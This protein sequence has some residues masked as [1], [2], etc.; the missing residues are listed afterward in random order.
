M[1]NRL[2]QSLSNKFANMSFVCAVL[3][4]GQHVMRV[5]SWHSPSWFAFQFVDLGIARI[6]VPYFF[7]ASGYFLAGHVGED[8]WHKRALV[9][10]LFSLVMPFLV[11]NF[12]YLICLNHFTF[13]SV[14]RALGL[15]PFMSP[16]LGVTWYVRSLL[17]LV[18]I[19]PVVVKIVGKLG[20]RLLQVMRF[21]RSVMRFRYGETRGGWR[22]CEGVSPCKD[23]LFSPLECI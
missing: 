8:G 18:L 16:E 11:W 14:V 21:I 5:H 4:V 20:G 6:A 7:L 10:R 2:T 1:G 13:A 9:K 3:V 22:W 12:A 19:S 17:L 23:L 15:N